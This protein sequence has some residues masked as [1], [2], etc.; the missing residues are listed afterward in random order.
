[1][2]HHPHTNISRVPTHR[3]AVVALIASLVC[4]PAVRAQER[5]D[6]A[7][8]ERIKSEEMNRSQVMDIMSW[9][10]DVYGP[11][12]TWSPN[13]LRARDW[14][15]GQLNA[16]GLA[17]VHEEP[18]NTPVGLGWENQRFSLNATSPVPF[19]VQAVPQAWSA[20]T[21]G[22]VSG[23]ARM[24]HAGCSDELRAQYA[25]QL[26]NAFVMMTPPPRC[27]PDPPEIMP[28]LAFCQ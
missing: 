14:T 18:W 12:L 19:I 8:I 6:V 21:K 25:G 27:V 16:W 3:R 7:T 20:S 13:A 26:K 9:L 17:N 2:R 10:S 22:T 5:V 11:R 15:M 1:M 23:P 28:P 24:I 4:A